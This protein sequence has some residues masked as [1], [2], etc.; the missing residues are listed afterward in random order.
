MSEETPVTKKRVVKKKTVKSVVPKK[1]LDWKDQIPMKFIDLSDDWCAS[2]G[3]IKSDLSREEVEEKLLEVGDEAKV[4]LLAGFKSVAHMRGLEQIKFEPLKLEKDYVVVKCT[5][6]FTPEE[7]MPLVSEG[8]ANSTSE[9]TSYPFSMYLESMAE[10]RAFI[11]A[12]RHGLNINI[13]GYEEIYGKSSGDNGLSGFDDDGS[14]LGPNETL[15]KIV[16]A[17]NKT[18]GDLRVFLDK[19]GYNKLEESMKD[20][21]DIPA[22]VCLEIVDLIQKRSP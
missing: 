4:V 17:K 2:K 12:V 7:G 16:E 9:N 11:R 14:I 6:V 10:N 18:I 8:L 22:E 5:L 15:K 1:D 21:S 19:K 3:I 13:V 20:F